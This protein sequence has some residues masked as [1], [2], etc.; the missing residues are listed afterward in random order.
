MHRTATSAAIVAVAALALS[1]CAQ[2]GGDAPSSPAPSTQAPTAEATAEPTGSPTGPA[3]GWQSFTTQDGAIS[4]RVPAGWSVDDRSALGE[5]SE[6]YNRGPGWLNELVILDAEGSQVLW[7]REHYGNDAVECPGDDLVEPLLSVPVAPYD[8]AG[9]AAMRDG[10]GREIELAV[11]GDVDPEIVQ[12][13]DQYVESGRGVVELALENQ[14]DPA[15]T[16]GYGGPFP[17]GGGVGLLSAVADSAAE[18]GYPDTAIAF[19][20]EAAAEAWLDGEE[21]ATIVE[22]MASLQIAWG[23]RPTV[24][25]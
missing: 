1:A 17:T 7:Y 21:S 23:P 6:M 3:D 8:E 14:G 22:V 18:G 5:A 24:A 19:E 9:L 13:G 2:P 25:P 11:H 16:C 20:S 12:Q 15:D 10:I 4:L